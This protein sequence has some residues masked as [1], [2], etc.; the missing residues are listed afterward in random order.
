[1][2]V[3][4]PGPEFPPATRED[5]LRRAGAV[6]NGTDFEEALVR[7]TGDGIRID[8]LYGR[9]AGARA[10][11]AVVAPWIVQ[12]RVD[13]PDAAKANGQA[14]E[15]LANGATGLTLVFNGHAAARGFGI[16]AGDLPRV[17]E[18]V[19]L[20]AVALR[21]EGDAGAATAMARL[22]AR[23]S[24]DPERLDVSFGLADPAPVKNLATQGFRGPFLEADG[25]ALH[26]RGA[27][28]AQELGAVLFGE[29]V[30]VR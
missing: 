16:T 8:P 11:R 28:E 17:L 5:W 3:L 22:I 18:G 25:R 24:V 14:L 2:T 20:H 29:L 9:E 4:S 10:E 15:D 6:L 26:E 13:H 12:A 27:T 1:M 23:Q 19:Q 7:M 21:V 30:S